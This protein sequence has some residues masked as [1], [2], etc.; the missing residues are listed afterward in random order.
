MAAVAAVVAVDVAGSKRCFFEE[1]FRLHRLSSEAELLRSPD[2]IVPIFG[3]Q[4]PPE[5]ILLRL[6]QPTFGVCVPKG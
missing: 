5:N 4:R 6:K 1:I 3:F 2:S